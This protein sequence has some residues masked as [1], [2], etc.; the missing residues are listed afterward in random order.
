VLAASVCALLPASAF[1]VDYLTADQAA[2]LMFPEAESFEP[3][4]I[5]LDTP[6]MQQLD[7]QGIRARS[8]QWTVRVAQRGDPFGCRNSDGSADRLSPA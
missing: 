1:A 4:D 8:A 3:R 5:K 7:T 6:Q 2:K